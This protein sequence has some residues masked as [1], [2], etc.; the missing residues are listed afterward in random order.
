M[1]TL[2]ILFFFLLSVLAVTAILSMLMPTMQKVEKTITINAP[3]SL[4]YQQ[5]IKL[6]NFNKYSVWS[7]R[8]SSAKFILAGTDGTVGASSSWKGHPDISGE[9]KIEITSLEENKKI[10]HHIS[11]IKPRKGKAESYFLLNESNGATSVTW[12]FELATP[13]P[14]NIFNLFFSLDKKMGKDFEEGLGTLKTVLEKMN[15]TA[16]AKTYI[17]EQMNFPATTFAAV[18]QVVKWADLTAFYMQHYPIL[19]EE[20]QKAGAS[21]GTTCSLFFAWDEKNQQTDV[22]A[23][24]PVAADF[25]TNNNIIQTVNIPAAKAVYV[26]YYGAYDK[27]PDAYASIRKYIIE[28]KLKEIPPSVEQYIID[29]SREKDTAK[30]LTKVVFLVK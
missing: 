9:G 28:N 5:L 13:R 20:V 24:V 25:R 15:N 1:R 6:E 14:W 4:V 12:H 21:P 27:L 23:A 26:N 16:S 17:V 3:A 8:D 22:A 29:P 10:A 18:R 7:Q 30:W 2:R 11:F 19:F